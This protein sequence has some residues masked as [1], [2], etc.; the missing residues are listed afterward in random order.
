MVDFCYDI[1]NQIKASNDSADIEAILET[2]IHQLSAKRGKS[3]R[4]RRMFM[5]NMIMALKYEKAE[6]L[7][8]HAK[9]KASVAIKHLETMRK[10]EPSSL[11]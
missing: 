4:T 3:D 6:G 8:E 10:R 1:I 2:A 7:T 11:F 9:A 5:M